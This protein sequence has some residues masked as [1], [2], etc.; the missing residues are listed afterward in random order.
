MPMRAGGAASFGAVTF[1]SEGF[2]TTPRLRPGPD[3]Q[4]LRSAKGSQQE[5]LL[6]LLVGD[7]S[8][9]IGAEGCGERENRAKIPAVVEL[10][11][12]RLTRVAGERLGAPVIWQALSTF[13]YG[14][15]IGA[16]LGAGI[17][18]S[19]FLF[20]GPGGRGWDEYFR[21]KRWRSKR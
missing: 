19:T 9:G 18:V 8:G 6:L 10:P 17:L 12:R 20:N 21:Q 16:V 15:L 2:G 4:S 5:T 7:V 14:A 11:V 3:L 1:T 13:L